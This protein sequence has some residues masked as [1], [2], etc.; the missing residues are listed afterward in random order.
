[1]DSGTYLLLIFCIGISVFLMVLIALTRNKTQLHRIFLAAVMEITVICLFVFFEAFFAD[2]DP[3]SPLI[4]WM[5]YFTYIG[6]SLLP[7]QIFLIG[8]SF[9]YSRIDFNWKY[10]FLFVI[11]ALTLVVAFT[12]NYHHWFYIQYTFGFVRPTIVMGWYFYVHT[13]YS[14]FMLLMGLGYVLFFS[15][16]NTGISVKQAS[17]MIIG[18]ILPL[19]V[20]LLYTLGVPWLNIFAT[21]IA[22]LTAIVCYMVGMLKFNLMKITPVALKTVVN[23]ISDSYIVVD[24]KLNIIDFNKSFIK[25]FSAFHN[26]KQNENLY[27]LLKIYFDPV[28]ISADMVLKDVKLTKETNQIVKTELNLKRGKEYNKYFEVEFTPV[29]AGNQYVATIILLKDITQRK[30][31]FDTI[32]ENQAIMMEKER[33]VSLGELVGG[34]AHNLKTPI[35]SASGALGQLEVLVQEYDKSVGDPEVTVE[36]HHEIAGEMDVAIKKIRTYIAY[37]SDVISTVKDQAVK[38]NSTLT[39]V[40][41]LHELIHRV[42][43]LMKYELIRQNCVLLKEIN[44][45]DKITIKGDVNSLVQIFDNIIVNAI[46]AYKGK[47]GKIILRINR[48]NNNIV[49]SIKDF[50]GGL[51]KSVMDSLFKKMVTTKGK[52]GTGI[53]LYISY[54]TIK[55]MF[56]G[57]MWFESQE[58]VGTEFFISIP[59]DVEGEVIHA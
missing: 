58:N 7:V 29:F 19:L 12:N 30:K 11:P 24:E 59:M 46:Q 20:N 25:N 23:R 43:I 5:E 47:K 1:M 42:D 48:D 14:Y 49:F 50:A 33:L 34:I 27:N 31:D 35:L 45:D 32:Q 13:I 2:K 21:P 22:M 26:I 6:S 16:K 44:I 18:S 4:I 53:G 55:G 37:M 17:V 52:N 38:L 57:N 39:G 10:I 8:R 28:E 15:V 3:D 54:S 36:D 56:R 41:T 9:A 40:F 51:D